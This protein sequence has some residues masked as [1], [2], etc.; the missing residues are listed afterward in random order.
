MRLLGR[1]AKWLGIFL[2]GVLLLV[3]VLIGGAIIAIDL[4]AGQR[5]I[6]ALA[7]KHS[8]GIFR[9]DG[10][11]GSIPTNLHLAHVELL[12]HDG[13]WLTLDDLTLRL[14][15]A[16]LLHRRLVI[17]ELHAASVAMLRLPPHSTTPPPAPE[18]PTTTVSIPSLPVQI[19]L[20]RL[21]IDRISV[22]QAV[23]HTAAINVGAEGSASVTGRDE[24]SVK[25]ALHDLDGSGTYTANGSLSGN[26]LTAHLAMDE[27]PKGMLSRLA[28][29]PD[30][31]ALHLAADLTGPQTAEALALTLTAGDLKAGA[32]GV[33][34][35]AGQAAK[36]AIDAHAPAM[37]PKPGMG[38]QK[39][40]I[41]LNT[42]GPFTKPT[43]TG[44]ITLEGLKA[45]GVSLKALNA[46][47]QGS[48]GAV[49]LHATLAGLAAPGLPPDLLGDTPITI[50]AAATLDAPDRPVKLTVTHPLL[51]LTVTGKTKPDLA[52][53]VV[54]DLPA[55]APFAAV[56]HQTI[57]G[58]AHI[59]AHATRP[60]DGATTGAQLA[61]DIHLTQ[62][63]PQVMALTGGEVHLAL[64][65]AMT[66]AALQLSS[67]TVHGKDI[68]LAA[69]GS[70]QTASQQLAL[71]WTLA[72]RRLADVA[73]QATGAIAMTGEA[74]GTQT[75]LSVT[76]DTT[77][78]VGMAQANRA[79]A[80]LSGPIALH[81]EATG[82][83][84]AP[85]AK[86]RLTGKPAGSP[87]DIAIDAA[88]GADGA[89]A[90]TID[91]ASWK[92]LSGAGKVAMAKG[93]TL[94]SGTLSLAIARLA[95]FGFL[96]GQPV[97]G[98]LALKLDAPP[99]Q[100]AHLDLKAKN[101]VFAQN[102]LGAL[103]VV[104]DVRD[105]A[106]NPLI[107]AR[108]TAAGIAAAGIHGA[109]HATAD[110]PLD[111]LALTLN[112]NLPDLK[113][114]PA[115]ADLR[116]TLDAKSK[117][118][119]LAVLN[120][121]WHGEQLRLLSPAR[122]DF[123]TTTGVD[124]LR[125]S[126]GTATLDASGTVKPSLNLQATIAN[127]T[128]ALAKPFAP[129]LHAAGRIDVEAKLT[130][131]LAA[132]VGTVTVHGAGL[133]QTVGTA[134]SLPPAN[135]N[136]TVR[137]AGKA[138]SVDARL[139]AGSGGHVAIN[140]TAPLSATGALAL[141]TAGRLDLAL[142]NP[143]LEAAGRRA[144]GILTLDIAIAGTAT[145][146]RISGTAN[147][148]HGDFQDFAQG[149][150]LAGMTA[151][152]RAEGDQL[153][154]DSFKAQAGTGTIGASGRIGVT[155][156]GLP[157][158]IT[159]TAHNAAPI[160][161]DLLTARMDANVHVGGS[162][163]SGISAKGLVRIDRADIQ[164]PDSLPPSVVLLKVHRPGDK[165]A[166]PAGPPLA[167]ALDLTLEAPRGIFV[168]G[169]GLNA[170][171]GGRMHV[172]G[173]LAELS[174]SGHFDMIRG[175]VSLVTA[176]LTFTKG[177]VGFDGGKISDPS[178]DFE[179]TSVS[180]TVTATLA[181]TGYAS[182]PKIVLSS[183]PTLPQDEVLAYI[184]F[185]RSSTQL[186]PFQIAEIASTLASFAGVGGGGVGGILNTVRQGLGLDQL[187]VGDSS[188]ATGAVNTKKQSAPTLQAGRY[189]A[190]G[191]YVGAIQ[192]TNGGNTGAQVQIDIARGLKLQTQVGSDS[193]GLGVT[194][195]FNY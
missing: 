128:P 118:L 35:L 30:L 150:H 120:A 142:A 164:V 14:S 92:S 3:L 32:H 91:R 134:A 36:L 49:S 57:A 81:I 39:V 86:I 54:L 72:L 192:G 102:S 25:L 82:L 172:G 136:A 168:R 29:M 11:S 79:V 169:H 127:I 162:I 80:S 5:E 4:P 191:V 69:H 165:A 47:I 94:P 105:P 66:Q 89:M 108:I 147:L 68:D 83:P 135:I 116:A 42:D 195:Q 70:R 90:A 178:I 124:H 58:S 167:I 59:T 75:D 133:R 115:S 185:N 149:I 22:A 130:G 132:P 179:A 152:L 12:D 107:S 176:T 163:A 143:I 160:Q 106:K 148:D 131:S 38:W 97:G 28:S 87:A 51:S 98:S 153:V 2:G 125:L 9:V 194:Y 41:A 141:H 104:G 181:V 37:K 65:A 93:A 166:P 74:H 138:A 151:R 121:A 71:A 156:P 126:L 64:S 61:A 161:S 76:T 119:A 177:Q 50:A 18:K 122:V 101:L 34:D 139:D 114:A 182:A 189:V 19:F 48:T 117:R 100:A 186:S 193:N 183:T 174:P 157:L 103:S 180:G 173:T 144:R 187:S 46:D 175:N 73:P 53:D 43:A 109:A 17:D 60:A 170:E 137:L 7:N 27:P 24:G 56:A 67:L 140:G 85:Q 99:G 95:D 158:D 40:D 16:P 20:N 110:G 88:R 184:L 6:V 159:V 154:I 33:I 55:L 188:S 171:L 10:L 1:I 111:A 123:G 155:A 78:T 26:A 52:A 8:G 77:G 63:M 45:Q 15:L 112:A 13:A 84:S 21:A 190:P 31:G 145:A 23:T 113:G 146:P 129:T 96:I 62:A 44:H